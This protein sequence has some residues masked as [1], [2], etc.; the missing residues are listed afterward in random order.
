MHFGLERSITAQFW[1]EQMRQD[2]RGAGSSM[3]NTARD[4]WR[5]YETSRYERGTTRDH[6]KGPGWIDDPLPT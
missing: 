5:A 1:T 2:F 3:Q 4:E 6:R